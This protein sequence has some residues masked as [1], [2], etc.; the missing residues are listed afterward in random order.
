MDK[1]LWIPSQDR[2]DRANLSRFMRFV[3]AE[4]GNA[5][6]NSYAPLYRFSVDQPEKFWTLLWDFVGIRGSGERSPVLLD[7]EGMATARWFSGVSLNFAQNLLRF[8][9]DRIAIRCHDVDGEHPPIS[10]AQLQRRVAAL[11]AAMRAAGVGVGDRV[12]A[13]L[14]NVPDALIAMV[15]TASVGAIWFGCPSRLARENDVATLLAPLTP[16]LLFLGDHLDL[17]VAALP[18]LETIV[19]VGAPNAAAD[20]RNR[21]VPLGDFVAAFADADLEFTSVAF[22]HPLYLT[23]T[24]LPDGAAEHVIHGTGGTLIQHLKEL[25]L[26][27]DLKREDKMFFHAGNGAMAWYWLASGLAIGSTLVLHAGAELAADATALWDLVDEV[28][29]SVLGLHSQ[30]LDAAATSG[31]Q[32]AQSHRLLSLKTILAA[33][34]PLAPESFEFVYRDIKERVLLSP[35]ST[36]GDTLACFALGAPTLPVWRGEVSCRGLGM[37]VE[38]LNAAGEAIVGEAGDLACSAPFPSMP[39]GFW[40]DPDHVRYNAAYFSRHA[41]R[42]C[43]GERA[44]LT[45]RESLVLE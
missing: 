7:A 42:W 23:H 34:A 20:G 41:G 2:V 22:D 29:I 16:K 3:R 14:P 44:T 27:V 39:L 33:G 9:D 25:V 43:R 5:D 36:G 24:T 31:L 6:L 19:S 10:Y 4:G 8:D 28:G 18:G 12:A 11:S 1:P 17:D 35:I 13:V 26:H 38:V 21:S 32:P 15:A 40:N 45:S 30:W 37:K